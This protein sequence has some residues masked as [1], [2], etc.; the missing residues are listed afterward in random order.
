MSV[1][2]VG[3]KANGQKTTKGVSIIE[4]GKPS[5]NPQ[6]NTITSSTTIFAATAAIAATDSS[7]GIQ[8]KILAL[9]SIFFILI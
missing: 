6:S 3:K 5:L 9:I 1:A 7:S 8:S 2:S 4:P